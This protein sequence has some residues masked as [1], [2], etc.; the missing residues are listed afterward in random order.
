MLYFASALSKRTVYEE[1]V[2]VFLKQFGLPT[3]TIV[4]TD[5]ENKG[6]GFVHWICMCVHG[7]PDVWEMGLTTISK[8][9]NRRGS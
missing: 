9:Y 1:H 6:P 8:S 2:L 4:A 3:L 5:A 7:E